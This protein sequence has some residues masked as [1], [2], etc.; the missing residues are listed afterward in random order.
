[1]VSDSKQL[2]VIVRGTGIE[3]D[4]KLSATRPAAK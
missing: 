1:M 4:A 3:D 2:T